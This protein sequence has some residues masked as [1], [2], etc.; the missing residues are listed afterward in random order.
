MIGL[1]LIWKKCFGV[2]G[3]R[4]S[5]W[6]GRTLSS[7]DEKQQFSGGRVLPSEGECWRQ[8][9]AVEAVLNSDKPAVFGSSTQK[10]RITSIPPTNKS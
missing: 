9:A 6:F 7:S 10:Y 3:V 4:Y 5:R 8:R 1:I 2:G